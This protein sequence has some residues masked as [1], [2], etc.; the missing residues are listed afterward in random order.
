MIVV[1]AT[2]FFTPPKVLPASVEVTIIQINLWY[3][4]VAECRVNTHDAR[5]KVQMDISVNNEIF[6]LSTTLN[7]TKLTLD[8]MNRQIREPIFTGLNDL[9]RN[10]LPVYCYTCTL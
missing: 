6:V 3:L 7:I 2:T 8:S 4:V 5:W 9:E 10:K 1:A